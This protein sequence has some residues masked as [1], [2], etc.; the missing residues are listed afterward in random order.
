VGEKAAPKENTE[1]PADYN[2]NEGR[3]TDQVPIEQE[4]TTRSDEPGAQADKVCGND[5]AAEKGVVGGRG[6]E[7]VPAA[8]GADQQQVQGKEAQESKEEPNKHTAEDAPER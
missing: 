6:Q 3:E 4:A 8:V 7:C 1:G 2:E 5:K